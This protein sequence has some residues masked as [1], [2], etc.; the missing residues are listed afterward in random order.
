LPIN[1][2]LGNE[3]DGHFWMRFDD[4]LDQFNYIVL[5]HTAIGDSW[6]RF[7]PHGWTE[8]LS[9]A[10]CPT[11]SIPIE[12][13]VN[14]YDLYSFAE[15][16]PHPGRLWRE[17]TFHGSWDARSSGGCLNYLSSFHRNPQVEANRTTRLES[18]TQIQFVANS[19][20]RNSRAV[21]IRLCL[22]RGRYCII[23]T[24]FY[25][26]CYTEFMLRLVGVPPISAFEFQ[27][28]VQLSAEP[29]IQ[30]Q[31]SNSSD[32]VT[33]PSTA[34]AR[35]R[36]VISRRVR[37][38][39]CSLGELLQ[40][41]CSS[42][43]MPGSGHDVVAELESVIRV[44]LIDIVLQPVSVESVARLIGRSNPQ[45]IKNS[46]APVFYVRLA[47]IGK[48]V[49]SGVHRSELLGLSMAHGIVRFDEAFL[50]DVGKY[51][52]HSKVVSIEVFIKNATF[53]ELHS[54]GIITLPNLTQP[55]R[56]MHQ[57]ALYPAKQKTPTC[58]FFRTRHRQ[59]ATNERGSPP[60]EH[61][62][63]RKRT[64]NSVVRSTPMIPDFLSATPSSLDPFTSVC[65]S[66]F[67]YSDSLLTPPT[68]G[69][70][71]SSS[72]STDDEDSMV[73]RCYSDLSHDWNDGRCGVLNI[74][75]S[76]FYVGY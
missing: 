27:N 34:A 41:D 16:L 18:F 73:V 5:C 3:S 9:K 19:L 62:V 24:T 39:F 30:T 28:E 26:D 61:F 43:G 46:S 75:I 37:S 49:E 66:S 58:A 45:S 69:D 10:S 52:A 40:W 70:D 11:C 50:F 36:L 44:L 32:H 2:C 33:V 63:R 38:W 71:K 6:F 29:F 68:E 12:G 74:E 35:R 60:L 20:Y 42:L 48:T 7:T 57:V 64:V 59:I 21:W 1:T 54:R 51:Q 72:G 23:P 8:I 22:D 17:I 4:F 14:D 25:P 55:L 13:D 15:S 76:R 65:R 47:H 31:Q 53:D 56:Q 67:E